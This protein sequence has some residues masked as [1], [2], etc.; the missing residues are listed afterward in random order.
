MK[1][2]SLA[3]FLAA[4][5]ATVLACEGECIVGITQAFLTNYTTHIDTVFGNVAQD[6]STLVS[7]GADKSAALIDPI[8]VAYNNA[9]YS[10]MEFSIFPSYFHGKCQRNGVNPPGCPNPDCPV[11]CGTPGSLV[12]F[13]PK[14][15]YIAY[16]Q[17]LSILK[18][19][20][21][22]GSSSY[23]EVEKAVVRA[24][25]KKE[26]RRLARS[27]DGGLHAMSKS[28]S[29][30]RRREEDVKKQLREIVERIPAQ[31]EKTCGGRATDDANALPECSWEET[32]KEYILTFP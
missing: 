3:V 24:A 9:S 29:S 1:F 26:R 11:V 6:I 21:S 31:L 4:V 23:Q 13:Y 5:P 14:L 8:V 16:N 32:M 27:E 20:T 18:T 22:P 7:H 15:R 30:L 19:L 12:H 2:T 17:T 28:A 10:G 25:G